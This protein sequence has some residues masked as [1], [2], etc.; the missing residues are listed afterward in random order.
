MRFYSG[1][2]Q[3]W[4]R[5]VGNHISFSLR[6]RKYGYFCCWTWRDAGTGAPSSALPAL[7][8]H[9][10]QIRTLLGKAAS[11]SEKRGTPKGGSAT[12]EGSVGGRGWLRA[13]GLPA[14]PTPPAGLLKPQFS[15]GQKE[16]GNHISASHLHGSVPPPPKSPRTAIG[17]FIPAATVSPLPACLLPYPPCHSPSSPSGPPQ[18]LW[19]N[20]TVRPSHSQNTGNSGS[21]K[22]EWKEW[23]CCTPS[24]RP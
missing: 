21:V 7:R 6:C 10:Q 20:V 9:R 11:S 24:P 1:S 14:A 23:M 17:V 3:P 22:T 2:D 12:S 13:Q 4:G 5:D 16:T 8:S 19:H 15:P 18:S